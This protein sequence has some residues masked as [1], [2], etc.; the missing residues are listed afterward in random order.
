MVKEFQK[1][2][3]VKLSDYFRQELESY[4][5]SNQMEYQLICSE[6]NR[7]FQIIKNNLSN[8]LINKLLDYNHNDVLVSCISE[9]IT[10]YKLN[11]YTNNINDNDLIYSPRIDIAISPTILIKRRKKASIGIF[12][13]TEDVD[14]FKKVHKLEFIKN[15]ENTLRQKSIE[16]FQ[17]YN[18]PYPHFSNCHNE[19]D[20]NNKRPLHLFGIEIE[21]Q[22]NVKHLMGDFL[23]ALSLSKIPIIVTPERNFEKLIKMLLFSAT[24]NNLKKVPIYNLLNKV[25]V[26]K[27]DQF[28]TTLNQFLTSRHIA[29]IT[30]ENYR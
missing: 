24:I 29:P 12:R 10:S 30:V 18:L 9:P 1:Q 17:E 28:R 20:Y 14:V 22:K 5:E 15:L 27:V 19:S 8:N 3:E 25:I 26:L 23:N 6:Y 11:D 16:N 13:L 7:Q 2:V 21:N 4:A